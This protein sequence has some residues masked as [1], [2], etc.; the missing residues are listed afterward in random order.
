[1][2]L[3]P[4]KRLASLAI[5]CASALALAA[6]GTSSGNT[7]TSASASANP[8]K[9]GVLNMLGSGDVDY[10]DPN[11]SYY[12]I[13]Y[14]NLREWSRQLFTYPATPGQTTTAVPDLATQMPTTANGGISA[15][16]KTYTITIRQGAKWNSSPARQ[17][18]AA[19]VVRGVQRTCNPQQPFGGTPDFAS[20]IEGYQTFC[21]GFA[22]VPKTAAAIASY[23]NNTP[24]PGVVAE[25]PSDGR[26]PPDAPGDLLRG[27]ADPARVLPGTRRGAQ[28]PARQH[29]A[30]AA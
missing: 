18:T 4:P 17:V 1:M 13:G 12:S 29:R 25:N 11:I 8:V 5:V 15:D 28:V 3:L 6:C 7:S 14:L 24:L 21:N 10:M 26:V 2:S 22:K 19:D 20:L 27:H 9:G 30:G 16:G 23:I